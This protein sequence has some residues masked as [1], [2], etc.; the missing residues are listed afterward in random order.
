VPRSVSRDG[1]MRTETLPDAFPQILWKYGQAIAALRFSVGRESSLPGSKRRIRQ[2]LLLAIGA[3]HDVKARERL[4]A[5]YVQLEA[6]ITDAEFELVRQSQESLSASTVPVPPID[7]IVPEKPSAL[8]L[9][10]A[11]GQTLA[12]AIVA[13]VAERMRARQQEVCAERSIDVQ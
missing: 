3:A 8:V 9:R 6:F 11:E 12:A 2:C 1:E 13:R 7:G 4:C 10:G 5:G